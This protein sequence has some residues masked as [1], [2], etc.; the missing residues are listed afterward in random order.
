MQIW[1]LNVNKS[2]NN[3]QGNILPPEPSYPTKQALNI[4][5]Q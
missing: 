3:I 5:M 4:P 2:T 1:N